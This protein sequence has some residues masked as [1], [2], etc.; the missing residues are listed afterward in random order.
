MEHALLDCESLEHA[1]YLQ[2]NLTALAAASPAVA[3]WLEANP[4]A[5][6]LFRERFFLHRPG[7]ADWRLDGGSSLFAVAPPPVF[8]RDWTPAEDASSREQLARSA[9]VVAGCGLGY[10]I[11]QLLRFLPP[12]HRI[13]VVEPRPEL[14][15]AALASTDYAPFIERGKILFLPPVREVVDHALQQLDVQFLFGRIDL[16]GDTPSRQ[17]GPEYAQ[18]TIMLRELLE[19]IAVELSTMRRRQDVMVGNELGNFQAAMEHGS[20]KGLADKGRGVHAVILGAGP[21]LEQ[22]A[23]LLAAAKDVLLVTAL[24]TLPALQRL[25]IRPHLCMAI[26]YSAGMRAVYDRL[27]PDYARGIPLLYSTKI[28]PDVVAG[29][30]GPRLPV[31]TRGGLGTYIFSD[32]EY[33]LNAGGNVSVALFRLLTWLGVKM[34]TLA[35]QD[36]AW[37]AEQSHVTGHHANCAAE[38]NRVPLKNA[39][40]EAIWSTVSYTTALRELGAEIVRSGVPVVNLYGGGA[41]IAGARQVDAAAWDAEALPASDAGSVARVLELLEQAR[42]PVARPTYPARSDQWSSSLRALLKHL[43]KCFKKV[44]KEQQAIGEAVSRLRAFLRQ[45]PLYLPYLYNEVMDVN[46]MLHLGRPFAPRDL[47]ALRQICSRVNTKVREMDRVVCGCGVNPGAGARSR[48]MRPAT[49][50]AA[51]IRSRSAL[52]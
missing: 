34:V 18:L 13:L 25:G 51:S 14:L 37:K 38:P 26:D 49:A 12:A 21:S 50:G 2:G 3:A 22:T 23:P 19:G 8:Y 4:Q 32:R 27:D 24:Q 16:K 31:W 6:P 35:G 42:Q 47:P 1:P 43:E 7:L 28:M 46:G 39:A 33:V 9:T 29:Y 40:G 15:L 20:I 11:N 52:G 10:G 44:E 5:G 30:P 41:V 45:D 36:F 48:A 17:L